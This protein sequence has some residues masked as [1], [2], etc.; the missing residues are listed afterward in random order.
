M[1]QVVTY[2]KRLEINLSVG[3]TREGNID[4]EFSSTFI[5]G[6]G[7]SCKILY[8]EVGPEVDPMGSDNLL[9][10]ANG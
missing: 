6:M 2:G 4:S 1:G 9:I 3:V 7:F 10:I 8:D 5:G